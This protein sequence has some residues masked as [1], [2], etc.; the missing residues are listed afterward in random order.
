MLSLEFY[1]WQ[2]YQVL[3][4]DLKERGG[5]DLSDCFIDEGTFVV[6]PKR[7]SSARERP[8]GASSSW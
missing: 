6:W 2:R 8:S 1:R 3:A 7:A 5:I 4:E